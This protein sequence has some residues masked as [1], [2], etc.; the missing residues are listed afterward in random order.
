MMQIVSLVASQWGAYTALCTH[1]VD[2][3]SFI[4][5]HKASVIPFYLQEF[6]I[7]VYKCINF[8]YIL[9]VIYFRASMKL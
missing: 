4:T 6:N 1:I 8:L 2:H 3:N 7:Y 9:N 5:D